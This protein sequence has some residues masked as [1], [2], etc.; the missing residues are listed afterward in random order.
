MDKKELYTQF[1]DL[2]DELKEVQ[3]TLQFVAYTLAAGDSDK[4]IHDTLP[5]ALYTVNRS[6]ERLWDRYT[7]LQKPLGQALSE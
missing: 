4:Y 3:S 7:D 6:L 1:E 2:N 5:G